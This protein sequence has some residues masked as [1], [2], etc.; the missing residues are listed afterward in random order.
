MRRALRATKCVTQSFRNGPLDG[1]LHDCLT[2]TYNAVHYEEENGITN[3]RGMKGFYR[4]LKRIELPSCYKVAVI[5]RACAI[6]KSRKK[7]QKRGTEIKHPK[8]LRP[9]VCIISGFFVTAKGR[10]FVPLKKRNE[11]ADVLLNHHAQRMIEG[12][13]LRS[14][15]ITPDSLLLCYSEEVKAIPVRTVY[16]VDRNEKNLTFGNEEKVIQL[17][18]SK[19]VRIRQT[20]R[21]IVKS[22][23]RPDV[24][25]RKKLASRYWKRC[26]NR[27]N[28]ILHAA[29]NLMLDEAVKDGAALAL[30]D[31]AGIRKMYRKGNGQGTDYRFRL[32]SWPYWKAY[33]ILEY[34]SASEGVTMITL[35]EAET[36]GSSSECASCG[37]RLHEPGREDAGH[38]RML[39]CQSCK[40]WADRD[41]N[42]A[43]NLSERGRSR[44]DRSLP[45]PESRSQ[46]VVLLAGE[47]GLAV[48]AT[49]RNGTTTARILRVDASKLRGHGWPDG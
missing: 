4:S 19:T 26:T 47:K 15:T 21:E 23:E 29:T 45:P 25:V 7:S 40:R 46:Q 20:T 49:R 41:V 12:K 28:Q 34:K 32:N 42:A 18:L 5:T 1:L 37:E 39:W 9:V 35:T 6:L 30:E 2:L 48:E 44:F 24:R 10:L 38:R 43:I 17:D 27:T 36:Y 14:L 33:R 8:P 31:L 22:F 3:R 16:G 13:K 11:Y